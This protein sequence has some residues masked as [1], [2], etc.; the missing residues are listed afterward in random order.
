MGYKIDEI[1]GIG[2]AYQQKLALA[3]IKTTEDLLDKCCNEPGRKKVS[4]QIGVSESQLLK[5]ANLADLMRISGIGKQYAELLESA[6]VDT[7]TELRT[8]NP[9]NLTAKLVEVQATK[10]LTQVAPN[11]TL[12]QGWIQ[13]A[14]RI[15]PRITY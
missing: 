11:A 9:E 14:K 1:E 3:D 10:H 6:G 13:D 4:V 15:A 8:R 5:W 7:V 12:V 2:P